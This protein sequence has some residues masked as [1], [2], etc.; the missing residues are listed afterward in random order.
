ML[1]LGVTNHTL[2]I[3]TELRIV[4]RQQ[5]EA[6]EHP[7][8]ELVDQRPV[9]EIGVDLP[10]RRDRTEVHDADVA[11]RRLVDIRFFRSDRHER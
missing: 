5:L 8:P 9:A 6:G 4:G 7:G 2:A 10:V 11:T 1:A 3:A